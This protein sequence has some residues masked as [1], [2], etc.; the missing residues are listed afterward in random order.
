MPQLTEMQRLLVTANN[1]L[2]KIS[3]PQGEVFVK[4]C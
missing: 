4:A 1:Q 3:H 2:S